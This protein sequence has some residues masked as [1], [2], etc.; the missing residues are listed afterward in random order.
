MSPSQERFL[1]FK[2]GE[3]AYAIPLLAVKEVIP[4]PETTALPQAKKEYVGIMNLRGQ[5]ISIVDLR[6]KL[7]IKAGD[8]T[9]E[10]VVIVE[11]H[12]VGVGLIVDSIEKV[13]NL[14]PQKIC[15]VPEVSS[16]VNGKYIQGVHQNSDYLVV[17]LDIASILN[18]DE[19]MK[20]NQAA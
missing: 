9:E 5:I 8:Q 18:I 14:D 15:E 6:S 12:G 7:G 17:L 10:A 1:E 13:L 11:V 3:E 20:L 2:L 16:Q 4:V 19:L